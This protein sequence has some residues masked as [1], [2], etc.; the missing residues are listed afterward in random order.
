MTFFPYA[1]ATDLDEWIDGDAPDNADALLR[2]ATIRVARACN[3]A[4]PDAAGDV[5]PALRDA[6]CAQAAT[7]VA[8]G[9]DPAK[10][11][12]DIAGPVKRSVILDAHVDRDTSAQSQA[13]VAVATGLCEESNDI[14]FVAGLLWLPG[15]VE[16]ADSGA[17]RPEAVEATSWQPW[18]EWPFL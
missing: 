4:L 14:L 10:G 2:S 13:A 12:T 15:D 8:L 11:G 17:C 3:L 6:T 16:I 1:T 9:I 7:W 18:S 5:D